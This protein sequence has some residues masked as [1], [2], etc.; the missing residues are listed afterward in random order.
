[1]DSKYAVHTRTT[2]EYGRDSPSS[3]E[4]LLAFRGSN[5]DK[6][7][8]SD[9]KMRRSFNF[10]EGSI[11]P[12]LRT[13]MELNEL[14]LKGPSAEMLLVCCGRYYLEARPATDLRGSCSKI[15]V[16]RLQSQDQEGVLLG[17]QRPCVRLKSVPKV[18]G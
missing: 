12:T 17:R 15:C 1:M 14:A 3:R 2:L 9:D 18:A 10:V 7:I 16:T 5:P 13:D 8:D 4:L 11:V 6:R